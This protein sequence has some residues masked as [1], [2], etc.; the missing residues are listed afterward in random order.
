LYKLNYMKKLITILLL[1]ITS[2][3]YSQKYHKDYVPDS[4]T[5]E[6]LEWVKQDIVRQLNEYRVKEGVPKVKWDDRFKPAADHHL[7]WLADNTTKFDHEQDTDIPNF[8]EISSPWERVR[9]L[10][11]K[12][13]NIYK[14]PA[15]ENSLQEHLYIGIEDHPSSHYSTQIV[16]MFKL[17]HA[18]WESLMT[19]THMFIYVDIDIR[20]NGNTWAGQFVH[21]LILMDEENKPLK[22]LTLKEVFNFCDNKKN[23]IGWT[24]KEIEEYYISKRIN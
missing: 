11:E 16:E 1:I 23:Y 15:H 7:Y 6:W 17:S 22:N 5:Y 4:L 2:I 10:C 12:D 20:V 24:N 18:H 9:I 21:C 14:G 19:P 8:E 3:G 13:S